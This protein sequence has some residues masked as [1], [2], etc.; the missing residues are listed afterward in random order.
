VVWT[1]LFADFQKKTGMPFSVDAA[2]IHLQGS[3]AEG[4]AKAAEYV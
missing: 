1:N 4:K 3:E 2:Y